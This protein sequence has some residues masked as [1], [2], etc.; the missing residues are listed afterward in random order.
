M[1]AGLMAWYYRAADL[2][3]GG[4]VVVSRRN[5]DQTLTAGPRGN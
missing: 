1:T 4:A 3:R 5:L 2:A